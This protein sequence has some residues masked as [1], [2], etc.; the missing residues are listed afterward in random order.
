MKKSNLFTLC[1][2]CFMMA[3]VMIFSAC[4]GN[5]HTAPSRNDTESTAL[6]TQPPATETLPVTEPEKQ[7]T[8]SSAETT[9][10]PQTEPATMLDTL[11]IGDSRTVGIMEYAGLDE[12]DFFCAT[13]MSVFS[14]RDERV[15][16]PSVGKVTLT[17]LLSNKKYGKIGIM[18]GVNEL[19]YSFQS[20]LDQ[21]SDLIA[22]IKS[23]QPDAEIYIQAN[24][25]VSKKRSDSDRSINNPAIDKLNSELAKYADNQTIFYLDAN[26]LFDDGEGNLSA[27]KTSDHVHLYAKYYAQWGQW[28]C[29]EMAR[30][31]KE[32]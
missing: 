17:E 31:A 32:G 12:A 29:Q 27:D 2:L 23:T 15:S 19:G 11:F 4:S 16:V 8:D 3:A 7:E 9:Q 21:Y 30:V 6:T 1:V 20:I 28:I 14:V 24:L 10:D 13:G 5:N 22:F 26:S 18:L 25:H